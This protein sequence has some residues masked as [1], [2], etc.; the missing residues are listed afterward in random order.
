MKG[1]TGHVRA[2][3][4]PT[5]PVLVFDH[6]EA[7]MTWSPTPPQDC[8]VAEL[9]HVTTGL[10]EVRGQAGDQSGVDF[11]TPTTPGQWYYARVRAFLEGEFSTWAASIA[12]ESPS[13]P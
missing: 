3:A 8:F 7:S 5:L 11:L 12:V 1:S 10:V 9:Y 2:P 4:A 13:G 6:D